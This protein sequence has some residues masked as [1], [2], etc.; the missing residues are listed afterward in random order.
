LK[1]DNNSAPLLLAMMG[2]ENSIDPVDV[3][4]GLRFE[5]VVLNGSQ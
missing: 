5:S 4:N 1:I 3:R 2:D